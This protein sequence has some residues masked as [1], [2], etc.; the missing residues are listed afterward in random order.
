M[1]H[2][3]ALV[4]CLALWLPQPP[5]ASTP[6]PPRLAE[7]VSTQ[8]EDAGLV[9]IG[10][11]VKRSGTLRN[12][13]DRPI[14]ARVVR[15]TC[16]CVSIDIANPVV[17]PGGTTAVDLTV[18][19][20]GGVGSQRHGAEFEI[21][22][23][24]DPPLR[25]QAV[26]LVAY[27]P[28]RVF[29]VRP[30]AIRATAIQGQIFTAECFVTRR[31]P[32]GLEVKQ[33]AFDFF[34]VPTAGAVDGEPASI[35]RRIHCTATPTLPGLYEGFIT[36]ETDSARL[37]SLA[38]PVAVRVLP[39]WNASPPGVVVTRPAHD[40]IEFTVRPRRPDDARVPSAASIDSGP[41]AARITPLPDDP[42]AWRVTLPDAGA[43]AR[44]PLATYVRVLDETG[45]EIARVLVAVPAPIDP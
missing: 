30:A 31:T 23:E 27:K 9:Q 41:I 1:K 11:V 29:E 2:P 33:V 3:P 45:A 24:G 38:V 14:R 17:P 35:T 4:L 34:G 32:G 28:D 15:T 19:V 7:L 18:A 25:Q 39:A 21:A 26:L 13:S 12:L 16:S 44:A 37:P 8:A 42:R 22:A 5:A 6:P 43:W 40:P 10:Q 20:T 36:F